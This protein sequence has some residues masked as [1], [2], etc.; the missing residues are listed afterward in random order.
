MAITFLDT[1]TSDNQEITYDFFIVKKP[2]SYKDHL[3][4][5]ESEGNSDPLKI[6]Q[7]RTV[8]DSGISYVQIWTQAN[9]NL[10]VGDEIWISNINSSYNGYHRVKTI[11]ATNSATM[12]TVSSAGNVDTGSMPDSA[13]WK[14]YWYQWSTDLKGETSTSFGGVLEKERRIDIT[15]YVLEC[16]Q[17]SFSGQDI[18]TNSNLH[19][20]VQLRILKYL[21]K[22]K[23]KE[24]S[25]DISKSENIFTENFYDSS[26]YGAKIYCCINL[27]DK[28]IEPFFIGFVID[29]K[30]SIDFVDL[31]LDNGTYEIKERQIEN[32]G[33]YVQDVIP[34]DNYRVGDGM[35]F[36]SNIWPISNGFFETWMYKR[37][38]RDIPK[39]AKDL[40]DNLPEK[41]GYNISGEHFINSIIKSEDN[42]FL[43]LAKTDDLFQLRER[44]FKITSTSDGDGKYVGEIE[45]ISSFEG[46]EVSLK[47]E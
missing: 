47:G 24:E 23:Q 5:L 3:T 15:K 6:I 16:Q 39:S 22:N 30:M 28:K 13:S 46:H 25:F 21:N 32:F 11:N 10:E 12:E 40:L 36:K 8:T 1:L 26:G 33:T 35:T 31:T 18:L 20:S 45:K 7:A 19:S 34:V 37:V 42:N 41:K 43:Q 38:E 44:K 27:N 29:V 14:F 9:N 4:P 17:I 2:P